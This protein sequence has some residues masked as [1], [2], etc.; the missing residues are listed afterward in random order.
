MGLCHIQIAL[1]KI[2][3]FIRTTTSH[4]RLIWVKH[5]RS[6]FP[7]DPGIYTWP[8]HFPPPKSIHYDLHFLHSPADLVDPIYTPTD[9][10]QIHVEGRQTLGHKAFQEQTAISTTH[11]IVYRI[12]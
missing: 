10:S 1:P 9:S 8:P 2:N 7:C 5:H 4:N 3:R 12:T 11:G 6:L